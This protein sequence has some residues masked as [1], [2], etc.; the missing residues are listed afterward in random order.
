M[1]WC[2]SSLL[3]TSVGVSTALCAHT[4]GRPV[5]AGVL[6]AWMSVSPFTLEG[7]ALALVSG[8]LDCVPWNQLPPR[9]EEGIN[10][11]LNH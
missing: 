11:L 3:L 9:P 4:Q 8:G 2:N 10:H 5:L 7:L 1:S 6:P